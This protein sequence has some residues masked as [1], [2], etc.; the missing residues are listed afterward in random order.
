MVFQGALFKF[1]A[2]APRADGF[3]AHMSKPP[4]RAPEFHAKGVVLLKGPK[5]AVLLMV[6]L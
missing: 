6:S 2:L 3:S 5:Q 1:H 4:D